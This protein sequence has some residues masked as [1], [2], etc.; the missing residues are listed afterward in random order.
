MRIFFILATI[1]L[2][3][4]PCFCQTLKSDTLLAHRN[5]LHAD[6]LLESTQ[7][8]NAIPFFRKAAAEY[9]KAG[10]TKQYF[11]A[12]NKLAQCYWRT[13]NYE[14]AQLTLR[15]VM[16]QIEMKLGTDH[17]QYANAL[18]QWANVMK[19]T[20][21][22]D[23][24]VHYFQRAL[25]IQKKVLRNGHPDI[26]FTL[27]NMGITY[28]DMGELT[29]ALQSLKSGLAIVSAS[30]GPNHLKIA[31]MYNNLGTVYQYREQYDSALLFFSRGLKVFEEK[32]DHSSIRVGSLHNNMGRCAFEMGNYDL[33]LKSQ[34]KACAIM[35]AVMGESHPY[36]AIAM[37]NLANTYEIIGNYKLALEYHGKAL[38]IARGVFGEQHELVGK[39]YGN[40]GVVYSGL[41][42][43]PL[44]VENHKKAIT[45]FENLYGPENV[46]LVRSYS[47]LGLAHVSLNEYDQAMKYFAKSE[48]LIKKHFGNTHSEMGDYYCNVAS[49]YIR[50]DQLDKAITHLKKAL[51]IYQNLLGPKHPQVSWILRE[52]GSSYFKKKSYPA[53]LA[54]YQQS[55]IANVADFSNESIDSFPNT[56]APISQLHLLSSLYGKAIVLDE[57]YTVA[58]NASQLKLALTSL[59]A[60]DTLIQKLKNKYSK[61][62]DQITLANT[63]SEIYELAISVSLKLYRKTS[64]SAYLKQAFYFAEKNKAEILSR[65][66]RSLA[67]KEIGLI[68]DHLIAVEQNL[69][70]DLMFYEVQVARLKSST[71]KADVTKL[72][73]YEALLFKANRVRDSLVIAFEQSYPEYYQLKYQRNVKSIEELQ[74][75]IPQHTAIVEYFAG[76]YGIHVFIIT[77]ENISAVTLND[78]DAI[79]KN[80]EQFREVTTLWHTAEQTDEAYLKFVSS[81]HALYNNLIKECLA[82]IPGDNAINTL[83]IIP[84]GKLAYVPFELLLTDNAQSEAL[85]NYSSLPYLI[86]K[87]TI[88][89]GYSAS[90]HFQEGWSSGRKPSRNYLGFAPSYKNYKPDNALG[91]FRDA[92]SGLKWNQKEVEETSGY[93]NGDN[94]LALNATELSFKKEA[95][96]YKI[97]HLAMHA[98]IDDDDPMQSKL[99]FEPNQSDTLNDGY[100]H[101]FELFNMEMNPEFVVLS[102]CNT[103]F[104]EL[105]KGEGIQSLAYAFAYAG[106]PSIVMS[107]WQVDDESTSKLMK[108]F[109]RNLSEGMDKSSAL[110]NAKLEF[111]KEPGNPYAN[112]SYW[113]AFVLVGDEQPLDL[114]G[115]TQMW[116]MAISCL[117]IIILAGIYIRNRRIKRLRQIE[118]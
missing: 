117:I 44:S 91:K 58:G 110:R 77:R 10:L 27:A 2:F 49:I 100:L 16:P 13:A 105:A 22:Y 70:T 32:K 64:Q 6:S 48:V 101:A 113:G 42:D 103:G 26:G 76:E 112:P 85:G 111:L 28:S 37:M 45:V 94:R 51:E 31:S 71:N 84:D 43:Y 39:L 11:A 1:S 63:A 23:S 115:N 65:S 33:A 25:T 56:D 59:Q 99:V 98:L 74:K 57:V 83:V 21:K 108:Y 96:E 18:I 15:K 95:G 66:V 61:F 68:P 9:Q 35:L 46:N 36:S 3:S 80:I 89:Y 54:Y 7:Y 116:I 79:N 90:L 62:E 38:A 12:S 20:G 52:L 29:L 30:L 107:Q 50:M 72:R 67:A 75:Q 5:A 4:L 102:A 82:R 40:L 47:N 97:L 69:K 19:E 87:F 41:R 81:S 73:H 8:Q 104:G 109:Y 118:Q 17:D 114:G 55:L 24:A 88:S 34:K 106:C 92:V 60:G 93:M 86:Q 53:S 78:A 14:M